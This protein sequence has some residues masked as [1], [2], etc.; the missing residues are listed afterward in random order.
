LLSNT[1][2]MR[3]GFIKRKFPEILIFDEYVLSFEVGFMKPH[4]QIYKEA[5][6]RAGFRAKECVFIDDREEN[7]EGAAKLG[8]NG[9]HMGPQTDLEVILKEKGLSF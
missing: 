8:I 2:T 4:P 9:I 5:L 6:E 1:D 3:F 7:I